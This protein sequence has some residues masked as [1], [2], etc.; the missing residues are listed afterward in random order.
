M[1]TNIL[2]HHGAAVLRIAIGFVMLAHAAGKIFVFTLA[3]TVAFFAQHGFPGWMAYPVIVA[4]LLGGALLVAGWGTR[5]VSALLI[6]IMIGAT[7]VHLPNGWM[8]TAEGGGWEYPVFLIFALG[9]Q[10]LLGDGAWALSNARKHTVS[11]DVA[12]IARG[13]VR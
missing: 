8:F 7:L 11:S 4:E 3:G 6:P 10:V 1:K 2:P 12:V 5:W 13:A 9:A